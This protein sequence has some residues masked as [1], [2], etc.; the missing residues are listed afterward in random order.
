MSSSYIVLYYL[1]VSVKSQSFVKGDKSPLTSWKFD[2][3]KNKI[4]LLLKHFIYV[5]LP[6]I[7]CI[8]SL[9]RNSFHMLFISVCVC[10][11]NLEKN[12][13]ISY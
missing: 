8:V 7:V 3:D 11:L 1:F 9:S 5:Y 12:Q 6:F 10:V 2:S 4:N 13:C